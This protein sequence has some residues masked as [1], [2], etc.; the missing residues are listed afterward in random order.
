MSQE[1]SPPQRHRDSI[2]RESRAKE[3]IKKV[4]MV[5][6]GAPESM[7]QEWQFKKSHPTAAAA[8][9]YPLAPSTQQSGHPAHAERRPRRPLAAAHLA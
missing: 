5:V 3:N 2:F 4:S 9:G 7:P 1:V 6:T 8:L